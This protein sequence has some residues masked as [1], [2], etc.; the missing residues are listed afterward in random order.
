[1]PPFVSVQGDI[2]Y[3][4]LPVIPEIPCRITDCTASLNSPLDESLR[5]RKPSSIHPKPKWPSKFHEPRTRKYRLI[6]GGPNQS[7]VLP[8][9]LDFRL[10]NTCATINLL[11]MTILV[12]PLAV[13]DLIGTKDTVLYS[14]GVGLVLKTG[15][16]VIGVFGF[17]CLAVLANLPTCCLF[18]I[19][20]NVTDSV[21]HDPCRGVPKFSAALRLIAIP[22]QRG[23][24]A[25]VNVYR[26]EFPTEAPECIAPAIIYRSYSTAG[27]GVGCCQQPTP[28]RTCP[29]PLQKRSRAG[30]PTKV[31]QIP[32]FRG[33]DV[34]AHSYARL[35][36]THEANLRC[37][38]RQKEKDVTSFL[39]FL[40][41]PDDQLPRGSKGI[42]GQ[43]RRLDALWSSRQFSLG[44]VNGPDSS[45]TVAPLHLVHQLRNLL[46]PDKMGGGGG[47][48]FDEKLYLQSYSLAD[49]LIQKSMTCLSLPGSAI[50]RDKNIPNA[51]SSP[52][53]RIIEEGLNREKSSE[54][55]PCAMSEAVPSEEF[56]VVSFPPEPIQ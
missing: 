17:I 24:V 31:P 34:G 38:R 22:A 49:E 51:L 47:L 29:S 30:T 44:R 5:H 1:M 37:L 6:T 39:Q 2:R 8:T 25:D 26:Q 43:S 3:D 12:S 45:I 20:P 18:K 53:R 36:M 32:I 55:A 42:E 15:M 41:G 19:S 14:D 13:S 7:W 56:P 21:I 33:V 52:R 35:A 50:L 48:R 28:R 54:E 27:S 40:T 4:S 10:T 16:V 23:S 46:R 11:D 9:L